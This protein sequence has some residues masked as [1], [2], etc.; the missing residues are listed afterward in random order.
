M[1]CSVAPL[2]DCCSVMRIVA[3]LYNGS[4]CCLAGKPM[5]LDHAPERGAAYLVAFLV[6]PGE[7][8]ERQYVSVALV[9][10]LHA[11]WSAPRA[12]HP[13]KPRGAEDLSACMAAASLEQDSDIAR[14]HMQAMLA[15]AAGSHHAR[16]GTDS[17]AA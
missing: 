7:M 9:N 15:V 3:M 4:Y 6:V 17:C 1:T 13:D 2:L 14:F 10:E 12:P 11:S 5:S 16:A 8:P